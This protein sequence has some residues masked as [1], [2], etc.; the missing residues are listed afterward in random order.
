MLFDTRMQVRGAI[1]ICEPD[2]TAKGRLRPEAILQR[3][4]T[5]YMRTDKTHK[6]Y[7]SVVSKQGK[8]L[9]VVIGSPFWTRIRKF[10]SRS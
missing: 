1:P 2:V 9:Y 4:A 10:L 8:R 7:G 3:A 6:V 5:S